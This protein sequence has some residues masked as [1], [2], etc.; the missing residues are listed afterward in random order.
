MEN[1]ETLVRL[2]ESRNPQ[3]T[4]KQYVTEV[5]GYKCCEDWS[6]DELIDEFGLGYVF[7]IKE[8]PATVNPL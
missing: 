8:R 5:C 2:Y 3:L 4:L 7:Y 1:K 6:R